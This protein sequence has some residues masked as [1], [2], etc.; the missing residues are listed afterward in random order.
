MRKILG[1]FKTA[2]ILPME[3][4]SCLLPPRIRLKANTSKFA[5]RMMKLSTRHPVNQEIHSEKDFVLPK[6][7]QISRIKYSLEK[8]MDEHIT[9]KIKPLAFQPWVSPPQYIINMNRNSA[10]LIA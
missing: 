7:T 9:E 6:P 3:V 10:E 5:L 2:P 4:E 8:I 1:V